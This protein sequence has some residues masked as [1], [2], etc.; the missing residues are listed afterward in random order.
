MSKLFNENNKSNNKIEGHN[1]Q[2][3]SKY[4]TNDELLSITTSHRTLNFRCV[5]NYN[6]L[7]KDATTGTVYSLEI[8]E[9]PKT[10]KPK[11]L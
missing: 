5:Y 6:D 4:P 2:N 8:E 9:D 1:L 7:P 11:N 3:K 10:K